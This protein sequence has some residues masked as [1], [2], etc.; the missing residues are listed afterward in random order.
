MRGMER[1]RK[2]RKE[3]VHGG[4]RERERVVGRVKEENGKGGGGG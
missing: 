3:R 1:W 2:R 4:E